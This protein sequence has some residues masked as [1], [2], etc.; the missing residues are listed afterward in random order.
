MSQA[1]SRSMEHLSLLVQLEQQVR[2]ADS[3]QALSFILLN[4]SRSLLEYRQAILWRCD[5]QSLQGFSGLAVVEQQAPMV[6]WLNRQCRR[7]QQADNARHIH[8]LTA[9]TVPAEDQPQWSEYCAQRLIWLPLQKAGGPLLGAL[10]LSRDVPLRDTERLLA[11]LLLD[12]Y[13]HAWSSLSGHRPQRQPLRRRKRLLWIAGLAAAAL[14]MLPVRQSV[15]APAEIVAR[16][17]AV[18]RAPLAAV[19]DRI[20]VQPNQRVTAGQPLVQLDTREQTNHLESARQAYAVADAELRQA[21]QQA[22]FDERS[23]A[24]LAT[25]Q[26]RREQARNDVEF[27]TANL[28]RLSIEAP[29]DGIAIF[30]DPSDWIGRPVNLGERIMLIAEPQDA[31]LE[32]QLP[33]ADAISLQAQTP[34]KLFLNTDPTS[35]L[36]AT[37]QRIGYRASVNP[38]GV[39]AYRLKSTFDTHDPRI[40]IGL[41][42]SAKLYAEPTVLFYYLLRR[43]LAA[44]RIHVGL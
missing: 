30:D 34:V 26:G 4:D 13:G 17:P 23:K 6:T 8:E 3:L 38:D 29:R 40:R 5:T 44:L 33:V 21:Q 36:D 37:L 35:P 39:M 1:Q 15:L 19:V 11:P 25:L 24:T 22:L 16:D 27:Y 7:W 14:L 42:G 41:K 32:I 12:C 43:P 28:K 2:A 20:L 31:D 9:S 10:L 18:L